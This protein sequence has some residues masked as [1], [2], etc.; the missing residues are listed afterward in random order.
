MGIP[1]NP[2]V[3]LI[4][5]DQGGRRDFCQLFFLQFWVMTLVTT[6]LLILRP[7]GYNTSGWNNMKQ[8][9]FTNYQFRH[10]SINHQQTMDRC[11]FLGSN[12]EWIIEIYI[13][14]LVILVFFGDHLFF[15]LLFTQPMGQHLHGISPRFTLTRWNHKVLMMHL[16]QVVSLYTTIKKY[17]KT[18][19][20]GGRLI[21]LY[22]RNILAHQQNSPP[23]LE[24]KTK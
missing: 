12:N 10:E 15:V 13:H 20:E 19:D 21:G 1:Q 22:E 6:I 18:V 8:P 9:V 16:S 3:S 5:W 4:E 2:L 24:A 17:T 7:A 23:E 14:C 11:W